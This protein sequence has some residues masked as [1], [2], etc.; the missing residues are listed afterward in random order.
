MD[1]NQIKYEFLET[2]GY[3]DALNFAKNLQIDE[4]DAIVAV[5]EDGTHHEIVNGL[6]QRPDKRKIPI[7]FLPGGTGNDNC[8]SF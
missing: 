3:L 1:Q 7:C 4:Y 5:G 8:G 2:K 6:M